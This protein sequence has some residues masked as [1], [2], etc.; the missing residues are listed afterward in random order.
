MGGTSRVQAFVGGDGVALH[1]LILGVVDTVLRDCVALC[2]FLIFHL[3]FV[4][5]VRVVVDASVLWWMR[6]FLC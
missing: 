4:A 1:L 6:V 2:H 5:G 3:L